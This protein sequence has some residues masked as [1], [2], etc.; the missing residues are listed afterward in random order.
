[1]CSISGHT[2]W[3]FWWTK[4]QWEWF[5]SE[6][7]CLLWLS[8]RQCSIPI[9]I[10][11]LLLSEGQREAWEP[12]KKQCSFAS[13]EGLRFGIALLW[14]TFCDSSCYPQIELLLELHLMSILK[15]VSVT[16]LGTIQHKRTFIIWVVSWKHSRLRRIRFPQNFSG[17]GR[18]F[19]DGICW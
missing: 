17:V 14:I 11:T 8:F 19:S 12:S 3:D 2:M 1:M 7:F 10:Y 6:C 15:P 9:F 5:F 16:F 18:L 4:L 13:R